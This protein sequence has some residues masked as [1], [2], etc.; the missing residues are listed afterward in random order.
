MAMVP[1]AVGALILF[2]LSS[3]GKA[4]A[5]PSKTED[6]NHPS[7]KAVELTSRD[8]LPN[9][10]AKAKPGA[11]LKVAYFGGSITAAEGWRPQTMDW[12]KKRYPETEWSEINAAIGGTGSDL[13]V[14][15]LQRD[16][17]DYHPDLVF[18]EFAV[19][20][21]GAAPA[22]IYACMEGIVR[23]IWKA[24]PLTDICFVY[25]L[26]DGM[27]AEMG[28]G[29]LPQSASAMEWIAD[30]YGIPS[31]EMALESARLIQSGQWV[32]TAP[33]SEVPADEAKG[34]P[35]RKAFAPDGCH[36]FA[37]TGHLMYTEAIK[38]SF[39]AMERT[40]KAGAHALP[41][42]FVADQHENAKM[43]SL[44]TT[45]LKEGWHAVDLKKDPIGRNFANRLPVL[46]MAETS[47][48]TLHFKFHGRSAF[49]YD[50]LGPDGGE[51][52]ITVDD[53][54]VSSARRFD[55]YCTY[56]RLGLT[57]LVSESESKDHEVTVRLT[58]KRFDKAEILKRNGNVIDSAARYEPLRWH[59]GALLL[60]GELL[61]VP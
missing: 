43:I 4:E 10:F 1:C 39:A 12:F 27:M 24:D 29:V 35:A 48:A 61:A 44:D 15:R 58:G 3:L 17:L 32:F 53:Q 21:N 20:D 38:R 45:L 37:D 11:K 41:T 57:Q 40:G 59:A 14:Y 16:V 60:D 55:A 19:N 9:Y 31:I 7:R 2:L 25:T 30:H 51:L 42:P 36:P 13:G 54:P 23:Q 8:G 22:Q 49:V 52:D 50:L 5:E 18:V 6:R 46:W 34:T 47:G 33:K 56:H 26:Q 28:A